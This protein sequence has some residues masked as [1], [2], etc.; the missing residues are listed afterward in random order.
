MG[1]ILIDLDKLCLVYLGDSG[2]ENQHGMGQY[3]VYGQSIRMQAMKHGNYEIAGDKHS[4]AFGQG[5][6]RQ[7]LYRSGRYP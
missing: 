1:S 4:K 7:G 5:K 3:T 6:G 2:A